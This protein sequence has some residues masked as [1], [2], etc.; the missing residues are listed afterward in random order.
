MQGRWRKLKGVVAA[1]VLLAVISGMG[2]APVQCFPAVQESEQELHWASEVKKGLTDFYRYYG[3]NSV[4][5]DEKA[6]PYAVFDFDNTTSI[7]DVEEQLIIWQ[8]DHLAFAIP[9]ERMKEVLLTGIPGDKLF[10][11]YGAEDGSGSKV[12]LSDAIDDAAEDYAF[13][14]RHGWI[15]P[16]GSV[17]PDEVLQT[18]EYQDFKAKMRWLYDAV[19]ETMDASVAY[20]WV[21]YWYTG[22]TP[23]EVYRLAYA[24]DEYYGGK[25]QGQSWTKGKYES[26]V[27]GKAGKVIVSYKNGVT[28]TPEMRSLYKDLA[29][30]GI[31]V[32]I[33]SASPLDVVRAA[34]DYFRLPGI[35]GIVAMT[36]RL[37]KSSR[38]MNEYDEVYHPQTQGVGKSETIEKIIAPK[39]QGRGPAFCAMDSQGDF[40]FCTEFKDTK[41]V[42]VINRIRTDD[43]A[44]CA[45]I[46]AYQ[47]EQGISLKLANLQ[48]DTKFLLQG[49]D[50]NGGVFRDDDETRLLGKDKAAY[51][52]AKALQVKEQLEQKKTIRQVCADNTK[53]KDYRGYKSRDL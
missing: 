27:H 10:L 40:N 41:E 30:Q 33:N 44:I 11:T 31:D 28:V 19:S 32:W 35:T 7:M 24:C 29:E 49:R 38:Y 46:S 53:L 8:L 42:L 26:P 51:L 5:Y 34:K 25:S 14:Y 12:S 37:D 52:S 50:E 13:L 22:M 17:L 36:N 3:K 21:T 39:Y 20:P 4:G 6:R 15:K 23:D 43:A 16:Q 47:K 45:G 48:G 1:G 9:P 18:V 2:P